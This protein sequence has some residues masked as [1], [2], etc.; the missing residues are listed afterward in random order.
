[1]G[2]QSP[3]IPA[4]SGLLL[5]ARREVA[6][7]RPHSIA[8][9]VVARREP[10]APGRQLGEQ[11]GSGLSRHRLVLAAVD[12]ARGALESG[13]ATTPDRFARPARAARRAVPVDLFQPQYASDRGS[14]RAFLR[15]NRVASIAS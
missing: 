1:M 6:A 13:S 2:A 10:P 9:R 5:A 7:I 8:P 12:V 3:P 15:R 14:A 4:G 11:P